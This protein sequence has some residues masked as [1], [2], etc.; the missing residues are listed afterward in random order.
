MYGNIIMDIDAIKISHNIWLIKILLFNVNNKINDTNDVIIASIKY[1]L[2][3]I[4]ILFTS[5]PNKQIAVA[6]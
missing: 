3:V 2:I 5:T 1:L 4:G 6:K